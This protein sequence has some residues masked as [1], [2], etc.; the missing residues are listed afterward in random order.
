MVTHDLD[1]Y[2]SVKLMLEFS[3]LM[4][5]R[6]QSAN[7]GWSRFLGLR[8]FGQF[9]PANSVRDQSVVAGE[10]PERPAQHHAC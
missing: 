3:R 10:C 2:E 8:R 7:A 9:L 5:Y 6:H 1:A 4:N